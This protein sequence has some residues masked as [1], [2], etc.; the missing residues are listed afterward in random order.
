MS[1]GVNGLSFHER[2][3]AVAVLRSSFLLRESAVS[4]EREGN[5]DNAVSVDAAAG[6]GH[7]AFG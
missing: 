6:R 7:V 2:L 4:I 3:C 5:L 1:I